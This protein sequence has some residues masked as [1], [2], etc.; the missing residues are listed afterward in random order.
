MGHRNDD[1][2]SAICACLRAIMVNALRLLVCTHLP[3]KHA[4]WLPLS[5]TPPP[6]ARSKANDV[7]SVCMVMHLPI[8]TLLII[9]TSAD[10]VLLGPRTHGK[11]ELVDDD[12]KAMKVIFSTLTAVSLVTEGEP[13]QST[14]T[15][16][17]ALA[18]HPFTPGLSLHRSTSLIILQLA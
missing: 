11:V 13:L 17:S 6:P 3:S 4:I 1:D 14:T 9:M 2:T 16:R 18:L 8:A 15:M 12:T 7:S 10:G 5:S